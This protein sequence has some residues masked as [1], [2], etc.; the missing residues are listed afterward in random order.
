[1]K[2]W[3]DRPSNQEVEDLLKTYFKHLQNGELDQALALVTNAYDD[4]EGTLYT[5]WQDHYLIHE[6]P[7]DSTFEGR[8]WIDNLNW[9]K[10]LTI[11]PTMEWMNDNIIWV[12]FIYRGEP[13]GYIGEF[14]VKNNNE[15]HFIERTV[16]RMA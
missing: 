11:Q 5:V 10:D 9:L 1:M 14:H 2:L 15:G 8:E 12:D 13:S 6:I 16:F 7:N 4:W 3:K